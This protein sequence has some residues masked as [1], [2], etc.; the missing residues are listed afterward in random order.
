M[1]QLERYSVHPLTLWETSSDRYDR[2]DI[3]I[4][5]GNNRKQDQQKHELHS[6]QIMW[7]SV[8]ISVGLMD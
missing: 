1:F 3:C 2:Q 7:S 4:Y 6:K 5:T 8:V